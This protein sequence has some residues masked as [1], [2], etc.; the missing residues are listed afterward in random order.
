MENEYFSINL[1]EN[2]EK[3]ILIL[4]ISGLG[5]ENEANS[6]ILLE[7]NFEYI[8]I[9]GLTN[10]KRDFF[11]NDLTH[12]SAKYLQQISKNFSK[13]ILI[14]HSMGGYLGFLL[15][16]YLE[17]DLYFI[18]SP[19][20]SLDRDELKLINDKE[21]SDFS[22]LLLTNSIENYCIDNVKFSY[23]ELNSPE[24]FIIVLDPKRNEDNKQF[25]LIKNKFPEA[26][27]ILIPNSGHLSLYLL[28]RDR[29]LSNFIKKNI[30]KNIDR[31]YIINIIDFILNWSLEK[32]ENK[33]SR[34]HILNQLFYINSHKNID[35]FNFTMGI[36]NNNDVYDYYFILDKYGRALSFCLTKKRYNYTPNAFNSIECI[37]ILFKKEC[38]N[39]NDPFCFYDGNYI[40]MNSHGIN[41]EI[42]T[43]KKNYIHVP[44]KNGMLEKIYQNIDFLSKLQ[45][46]SVLEYNKKIIPKKVK[47]NVLLNIFTRK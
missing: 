34:I 21:E 11:I 12:D 22:E 25:N 30:C 31:N 3:D 1:K 36:D 23:V 6:Y 4:T 5:H 26:N 37:P 32:L 18:C 8:N 24:K 29:I 39:Y 42:N 46:F 2:K 15:D 10:K 7:N 17:Y 45:I 41:D 40:E 9:C 28:E 13:K 43:M 14:T 27:V 16:K 20:L 35:Y 47:K 19:Y 33:E 38:N 44:I